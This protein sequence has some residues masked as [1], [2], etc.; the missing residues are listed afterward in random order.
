MLTAIYAIKNIDGA[1]HDLWEASEELEYY[2]EITEKP[3]KEIIPDEIIIKSFSRMDK[4]SFAMAI[5]LVSGL[6]TFLVRTSVQ[7]L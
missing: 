7:Y 5:G 4:L 6:L 3:S 1:S 2:E